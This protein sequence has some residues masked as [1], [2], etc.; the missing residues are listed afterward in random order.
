LLVGLYLP[1][2]GGQEVGDRLLSRVLRRVPQCCDKRL[3]FGRGGEV[4]FG[5]IR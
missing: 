3:L 2:Q 4:V 1:M 5:S